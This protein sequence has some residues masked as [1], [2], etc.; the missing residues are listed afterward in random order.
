MK[1]NPEALT[2]INISF[3][4]NTPMIN[5]AIIKVMRIEEMITKEKKRPVLFTN[6]SLEK[7]STV[8]MLINLGSEII[9]VR[10]EG[11]FS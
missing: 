7:C 3:L 10:I 5:H 6:S 4:P 1:H 8:F 11:N 9:Q 2:A